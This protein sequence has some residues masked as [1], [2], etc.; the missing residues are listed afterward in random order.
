MA[1]QTRTV[2]EQA[3]GQR[4]TVVLFC[5]ATMLFWMAQYV[6]VP[7][8]PTYAQSRLNS[9]TL[10]GTVLS[11]YGLWQLLVRLPL[12]IAADWLGRRKPLLLVG[13]ALCGIGA[14]LLQTATDF[15]GLML[16]RAVTGLAA[17]TWV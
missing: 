7:T 12:G 3:P 15:S 1:D 16:G 10:V 14:W 6:Y 11:M 5:A 17:C 2:S 13:F 4:R 9:L 8:L